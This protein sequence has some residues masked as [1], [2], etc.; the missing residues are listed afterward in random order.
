M[1]RNDVQRATGT[2]HDK[3]SKSTECIVPRVNICK[4]QIG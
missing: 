1:N 2:E 3:M 4:V